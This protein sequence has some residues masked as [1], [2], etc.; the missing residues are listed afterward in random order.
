MNPELRPKLVG[1]RVKRVE[2]PRLLTGHGKYV[3]DVHIPNL[4]H[5]AYRRS[6]YAHAK[7]TGID[8]SE[9]A[10]LSGVRAVITAQD[11]VGQV[12]PL[13][14]K[15]RMKNYQPTTLTILADEKV[16][17]VG[18][19]VVAVV[20]EDRY[21][22]EDAAALVMIDYE[23][24][25]NLIN[26]E[27]AIKSDAP[28]LH[29]DLFSNVLVS[30]AFERGDVTEAFEQAAVKV[31]G[32]FR[33]HRKTPTAL[34]NRAYLAEYDPARRSL[35]LH[36][37]TQAPGIIRDILV[38]ALDIPGNRVRVIAPDVGGGFGGKVTLYPEELLVCILARK[39]GQPIK[40]TGDRL[41]DL[42]STTQSFDEI[43][44]AELAFDTR[45]QIVGL[46][47]D[48]IGDVGAYSIYPWTAGLEPVQVVSF[49]P[50][51]Y[52]MPAY[53]AQ[54]RAVATSKT[55]MGPYRGV[56]RPISTFVM[57]RL[58]DMA[59][60]KL[61]L[62][63]REIR[64]R[65]M[66][67]P[68]EFPYRTASGIIWDHSSFTECLH[69]A[70]E[71]INYETLRQEQAQAKEE[72]RWMGIGLAAYAELT[73]IGSRIS[74]SPGMPINT[75][76]ET[77]TISIDSTGGVTAAFGVSSHGQGLETTLAQIVA[78][79]LGVRLEDIT[80]IHGDSSAVPHSTGTYASRSGVLGAG[81]GALSARAVREKLVK[82][83]AE[84]F[85]AGLDDIEIDNSRLSVRGTST[86]MTLLALARAF[87]SEMGRLSK[88]FKDEVG[89]LTATK[90]YDPL[91]GTTSSATHLVVVDIDP[92]TYRVTIRNY[93]V[94]E[95][96]GKLINP[97]I[98]DGQVYGG[99]AQGVG[100]AQF[101]EVVYDAQGQ[102]LTANLADYVI[103]SA[104]ETPTIDIIHIE[105]E[106]S[107]TIGGFRGMGEGGTI[108]AP[109]AIANAVADALAPLGIE[110]FELPITSE[111]LFQL[112]RQAQE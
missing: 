45:G 86:S 3:D 103:P 56:G 64:Q 69:A 32:R 73:G 98:V 58:M 30:R 14:A 111:R 107:A 36:S 81:A 55:P 84:L 1:S 51:P 44:D 71:S 62:D 35:T 85:E 102:V 6:D 79:E 31:G 26:P 10:K 88:D 108:G 94:A 17:F 19:P 67:Q 29:D 63:P 101:E 112:V 82:V 99:V 15:S 109:A 100:A 60:K 11:L 95:D 74:A 12:N 8:T 24:L 78:D 96:C 27:E 52:R 97:M 23:P 37:S 110:I 25:V 61:G 54:V 72:G 38:E 21:I 18:E 106:L 28:K 41:E 13:H 57:E 80:I 7:I 9:A 40:W 46:Q 34:E 105:S 5:I 92:G 65:N 75:G 47:A 16:R 90:M 39:L 68:D 83:A 33:F 50:G 2:D 48:V 49:L 22:A 4:L 91:F 43:V 53:K 20:A 76:T 70:C 93:V 104:V 66:V 89:N 42:V 59:A 87:Y 77:C